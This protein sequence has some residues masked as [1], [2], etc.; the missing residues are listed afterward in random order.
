[1]G[2]Q[3]CTD[4]K[5]QAVPSSSLW[6]NRGNVIALPQSRQRLPL[7]VHRLSGPISADDGSP[8]T[9]C[10]LSATPTPEST[11]PNL[12][13]NCQDPR[14]VVQGQPRG[15]CTSVPTMYALTGPFW[16]AREVGTRK[17]PSPVG[18]Q[19]RCAAVPQW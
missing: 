9:P 17:A 6:R 13:M 12:E 10:L 19:L 11:H 18:R 3:I 14:T 8:S 16:R 5:A 7:R 4:Q 2:C 15:L 1:M